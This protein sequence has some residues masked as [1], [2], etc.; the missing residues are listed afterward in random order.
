MLRVKLPQGVVHTTQLRALAHVAE[1]YTRGFGHVTTRQN[2]Q[3]HFMKLSHLEPAMRA[4]EAAGLTCKEACGNSVRNITAC[5]YAG[6]SAT[7]VFDVTPYAE[8]MTRHFLRHPLSSSLPR[9]FK[10]AFEGC[11]ED[12]AYTAIHD[13]GLRAVSRVAQDGT[14]ERGFLVKVG[15]GTA[16]A[17]RSGGLLEAFVPAG[18]IL[19]VAEAIVRVFH[20][21]G[22]REHRKR[23][24]MKFLIQSMGWQAWRAAFDAELRAVRA[25]G[26]VGLPFDAERPPQEQA[27]ESRAAAP[28][29]GDVALQVATGITRGP[30]LHP[31]VQPILDPS[32]ADY[33]HW[34]RTNVR[35]QR[36]PGYSLVTVTLP[37]GDFTAAQMRVLAD[38]AAAYAD[39]TVRL[40]VGQN[41]VLR[42]VPTGEVPALYGQLLAAGLGLPDANSLADVTSCPGAE[43]C[44]LAVTQ[45]R[46]LARTLGDFL[47]QRP[48]LVARAADAKI[49]IS[50]C[51]NGCGQHHIADIGFQGGMRR[52]GKR[53]VPQYFVMVGGGVAADGAHFG[54]VAA[55]IPA[56]RLTQAVECLLDL[57]AANKSHDE[58]ASA[59]F[60][61]AEL[62]QVK[63]AIAHLE[64]LTTEQADDEDFIDLGEAAAFVPETQAGECAS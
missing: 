5:P 45:S 37:L 24:R 25:D 48:D 28:R 40:T 62:A 3:Y 4:L 60:R 13:I 27:P 18:D 10:V 38:M 50:G 42:W 36:Q 39:A 55:K 41:L 21:L 12:H 2:I 54:R 53:A 59:Y 58:T 22:D 49:K 23:N 26:G 33:A 57:Y 64:P 43:S 11:S 52:V 6:V 29:P 1:A 8:A 15:G 7:E 51:P 14:P 56:R 19:S 9:K 46:G 61:R 30:G 44:K 63:Q 35:P 31:T 32:A 20:R 16:I 47:R 17:C 34:Q